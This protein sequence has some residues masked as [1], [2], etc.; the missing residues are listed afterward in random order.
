MAFFVTAS[1]PLPSRVNLGEQ[2]NVFGPFFTKT[3]ADSWIA[4]LAEEDMLEVKFNFFE[5]D[6]F[7]A[8]GE[9]VN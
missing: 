2:E 7:I 8:F 5:V 9:E 3:E 4:E 1:P 6:D